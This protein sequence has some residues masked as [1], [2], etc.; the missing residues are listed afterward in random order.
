MRQ[1]N[2][3]WKLVLAILSLVFTVLIWGQGLNESF[4]RPSVTPKLSLRQNEIAL[5]AEPS[6]PAS[7]KSTLF[8]ENPAHVLKGHLDEIP[9][10]ELSE[11]E[12]LISAALETSGRESM[13]L[14]TF[15]LDEVSLEPISSKFVIEGI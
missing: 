13:D 11:R 1:T 12:R 7:I 3:T 8:S 2:P 15:S 6:I 4:D 10:D 14:L 5:L 9:K